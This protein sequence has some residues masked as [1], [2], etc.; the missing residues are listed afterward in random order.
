MAH[1]RRER[2]VDEAESWHSHRRAAGSDSESVRV[3][4]S[5]TA[6]SLLPG[7][8]AGSV[9]HRD[10]GP[11]G[12]R[13]AR[14]TGAYAG[15]GGRDPGE[16]EWHARR[17]ADSKGRGAA[18]AGIRPLATDPGGSPGST[19]KASR[20]HRIR[21]EPNGL[22]RISGGKF[23]TYR[24]MAAQTV[25]AAIGRVA[26]RARPSRTTETRSPGRPQWPSSMPSPRPSPASRAWIQ[27]ERSGSSRA[28]HSC[29]GGHRNSVGSSICSGHWDPALRSSK[30]R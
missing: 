27:I 10:D 3:D 12:P 28:R 26:A 25:D 5:D 15:R 7:P 22:I 14:P 18:F 30:R 20:E 16:R 29:L 1:S 2:P 9:G 23:T 11:R 17:R 19:V 24:L 13:F 8:L 6:S 4:P 21:T